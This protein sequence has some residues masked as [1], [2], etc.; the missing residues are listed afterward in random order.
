VSVV[1]VVDGPESPWPLL[2]AP[3]AALFLLWLL[4]LLLTQLLTLAIPGWS[5]FGDRFSALWRRAKRKKSG[6]VG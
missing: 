6:D 3:F 4:K 1:A 2:I 5:G